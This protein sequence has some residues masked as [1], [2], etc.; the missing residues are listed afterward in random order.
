M[1]R[2]KLYYIGMDIHKRS[3]TYCI[4]SR[5]GRVKEEGSLEADPMTL[6]Q[7]VRRLRFRWVAG[8]EATLFC[9]WV[10]DVMSEFEGEVKVGNTWKLKAISCAKNKSDSLDADTL[11]ELLRVDHFPACYMAPAWMRELK[12]VLRYRKLLVRQMVQLKNRSAGLLMQCGERYNKQKLHGRDYFAQLLPRLQETPESA[13]GLLRLGHQQIH[14]L[15]T[16]EKQLVLDLTRHP[17]LAERIER[18]QTIPG[19]GPLTALT[20]A[21]EIGE[22][23]RFATQRQAIS[24]CGLCPGQRESG[25]K[26]YKQPISR[27]RNAHLQTAL[28]E[29]AKLA[30]RY[31]PDLKAFHDRLREQGKPAN[32]ITLEVARKLVRHLMAVDK[33]QEPYKVKNKTE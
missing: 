7:W 21:L 8:M 20:W 12:R 6:R 15:R 10:Y 23:E 29:A 4:K 18:L 13:R 27:Q 16:L 32:I 5:D 28:I 14:H 19:V 24:Y 2:R 3:I 30:P 22:P 11:A 17:L 9:D 33:R 25:G 1:S 26:V 31:N